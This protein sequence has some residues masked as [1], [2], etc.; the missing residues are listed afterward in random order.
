MSTVLQ[1]LRGGASRADLTS[2]APEV[3]AYFMDGSSALAADLYDDEREA[4]QAAGRYVATPVV[5]DRWEKVGRALG[6]ATEP[7]LE[8]DLATTGDRLAEV[9][10]L[11][12]ARPYRDTILENQKR[13]PAA[14]GWR[15]IASGDGCKLCQ[16]LA[17]RGAVYRESTA[18]FA[19]HSN[20]RCTAAPV[21]E[22]QDG[23]E[24]SAMQYVA[25]K[26]RTTARDRA[27]LRD[28]LNEHF[29]D[30]PG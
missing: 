4:A 17:S 23:P 22:G 30:A 24:A 3:L 10:Q 15:R 25:S 5:L 16:L 27:R 19:T 14:V 13:D 2:A 8:D 11:E 12:S 29:P 20:C 26:R 28:Y 7:L 6:W 21:F 9:I 18:R 1:L